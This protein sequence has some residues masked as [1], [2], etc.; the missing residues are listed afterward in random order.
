[1]SGRFRDTGLS[2]WPQNDLKHLTVKNPLYTE[3]LPRGPSFTPFRSTKRRFRDTRLSKIG[4]ALNDPRMTLS[5]LLSILICHRHV[6]ALA[7]H[8]SDNIGRQNAECGWNCKEPIIAQ[9]SGAACSLG[10]Y[11]C[12]NVCVSGLQKASE[13]LKAFSW[14]FLI[15]CLVLFPWTPGRS[16]HVVIMAEICTVHVLLSMQSGRCTGTMVICQCAYYLPYFIE[17]L[18]HRDFLS[19]VMADIHFSFDLSIYHTLLAKY[20]HFR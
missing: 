15:C 17:S 20:I 13:A 8:D 6:F 11:K 12:K 19:S 18:M 4:P 5:T 14:G 9:H 16:F 3:Y 1:M 7:I 10:P 2:K